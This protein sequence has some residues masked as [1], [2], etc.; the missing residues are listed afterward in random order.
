LGAIKTCQRASSYA[1]PAAWNSL[2]PS[3]QQ[4]DDQHRFFQATFEDT[5]FFI[6]RFNLV[7]ANFI[8]FNFFFF[9]FQFYSSFIVNHCKWFLFYFILF[10][11]ID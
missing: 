3:L 5:S 6:R 2:P 1:A 4:T 8:H 9:N 11:F 7:L 10:Y